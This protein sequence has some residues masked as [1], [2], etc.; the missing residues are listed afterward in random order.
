[1]K[2]KK[3]KNLKLS[4]KKIA[5]FDRNQIVGGDNTRWRYAGTY[6]CCQIY[7]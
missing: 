4:K 1:M 6:Y 7:L 2:K 3:L 5:K